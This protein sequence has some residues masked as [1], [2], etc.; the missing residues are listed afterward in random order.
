MSNTGEKF[1]LV[2]EPFMLPQKCAACG[3]QKLIPYIDF[4]L[5]IKRYGRVYF[6]KECLIEAANVI[7]Y[8]APVSSQL[9]ELERLKEKNANLTHLLTVDLHGLRTY[10][11]SVLPESGNDEQVEPAVIEPVKR[12]PGRPKRSEQG[13]S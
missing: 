6:C 10:L 12:G 7:N 9:E 13:T 8:T 2:D 3:T 1:Q 4:G 5:N 11:D